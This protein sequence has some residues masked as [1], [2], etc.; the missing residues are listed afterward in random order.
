MVPFIP[1]IIAGVASVTAMAVANRVSK[2]ISDQ[3]DISIN[4]GYEKASR[5]FEKKYQKQYSDF[6]KKEKMLI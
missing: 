1:L 6:M 5:E 3:R 4:E 2:F